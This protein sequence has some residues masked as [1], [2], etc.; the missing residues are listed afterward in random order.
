MALS[1]KKRYGFLHVIEDI[2][3]V[4]DESHLRPF[5]NLLV[6]CVVRVLGS[7]TSSLDAAKGAGSS[8]VENHSSAD[9]KG[10]SVVN[11]VQ[12]MFKFVEYADPLFDVN[13]NLYG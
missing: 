10:S 1:F 2:I 8:V 9:E 4:F 7:C 6:G 11:L 3:G 5:L 12:V 13:Q